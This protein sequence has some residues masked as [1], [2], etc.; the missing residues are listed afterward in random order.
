MCIKNSFK[1]FG[2]IMQK[3]E[4]LCHQT[5][6]IELLCE[7]S[8]PY[9]TIADIGCDHAYVSIHLARNG[10][11]VIASDV[12]KGPLEKAQK[13]IKTFGLSDKIELRLCSG[14][15]AYKP[16]ETEEIIIAGMGGKVISDILKEGLEVAKS[17]KVLFL[18]P[19]TSSEELR[20]FLYENGFKIKDEHLVSEDR[21]IYTIIEAVYEKTE[22]FSPLDL[23]I[24]PAIR[25]KLDSPT[26]YQYSL[27][28]YNEFK[29]IIKGLE[30]SS[31]KESSLS[32]YERLK[33]E[34]EK[35]LENGKA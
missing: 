35:I 18:Q 24:S 15:T 2:E 4:M 13:N 26:Y 5:P 27:K 10:K 6:R 30:K 14:L 12:S 11:K 22:S 16:Y 19:M 9:K 8:R 20:G 21:R 25:K 31:G 1:K 33:E 28:I 17:A 7:L 23:Y 34:S 29:K 32:Y 3:Q